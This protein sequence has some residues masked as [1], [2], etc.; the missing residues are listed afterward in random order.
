MDP[1]S[2]NESPNLNLPL[3]NV[4]QNPYNQA[5]LNQDIKPGSIEQLPEPLGVAGPI[6]D[7]T[8]PFT[9]TAYPAAP[10]QSDQSASSASN[11]FPGQTPIS[12]F[13]AVAGDSKRLEAAWMLKLKQII[14]STKNDPYLQAK[15]IAEAK[16]DYIK[17]RFNKDIKL[18]NG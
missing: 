14:N 6:Q 7:A 13:P 16:A 18:N 11:S 15:S 12:N 3:P 8:I 2:L 9:P 10:I 4:E 17:K 5:Y 1:S